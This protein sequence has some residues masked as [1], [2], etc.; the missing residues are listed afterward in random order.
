MQLLRNFRGSYLDLSFSAAERGA[1]IL[2]LHCATIDAVIYWLQN[3]ML[4]W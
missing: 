1:L 4:G 3:M 2:E